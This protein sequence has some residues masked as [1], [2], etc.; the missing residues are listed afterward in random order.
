MISETAYLAILTVI[1]A[2]RFFELWLSRRNAERA[3][4]RGG[5]ESGQAHY[6]VLVILHVLFIASCALE[7]LLHAPALPPSLEG[8][9]LVGAV[10]AQFLRYWAVLTLGDRWNTRIIVIPGQPP[11]TAGAFRY[12]RHPNYLAVIVEIACLPMI[13]GLWITAI[14]FSLANA[15]ILSVRISAEELAMGQTY[16]EL[17]AS[18]ARFIP[19][20]GR[21]R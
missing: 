12:V 16:A 2:E 6:K 4:S 21:R 11:I 5:I 19:G 1:V 10:G 20:S 18:H 17:F 8:L 13:R 14:A 15:I 3:F 9:A 7:S